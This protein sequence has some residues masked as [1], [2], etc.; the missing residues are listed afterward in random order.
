V[1]AV[2]LRVYSIVLIIIL[3]YAKCVRMFIYKK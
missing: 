1:A 3:P 2:S